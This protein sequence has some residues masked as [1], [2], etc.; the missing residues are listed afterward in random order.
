[1]NNQE[2]KHT[3]F[4]EVIGFSNIDS[5]ESSV[6]IVANWQAIEQLDY[7]NDS[8]WILDDYDV[9][10]NENA[11]EGEWTFEKGD[12]SIFLR[13]FAGKNDQQARE[14]F[15]SI[16]SATMMMQIPYIKTDTKIGALSVKSPEPNAQTFIWIYHNLCFHL[17]GFDTDI[18]M[19]YLAK[20]I[21]EI[22]KAGLVDDLSQHINFVEK[23]SIA[24]KKIAIQ[25]IFQIKPILSEEAAKYPENYM[26]DFQ[27][28][29]EII[30]IFRQEDNHVFF[31]A[32]KEGKTQIMLKVINKVNLLSSSHKIN[33]TID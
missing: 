5:T 21:Q 27:R 6:G 11:C 2:D 9:T 19:E 4:K 16:T 12:K 3:Q 25:D 32:L 10:S 24:P 14:H 30:D 31:K 8:S 23:I 13:I 17:R 20:E 7:L 18:K 29:M 28:D 33:I 26:L 1:M 15:L 22:A